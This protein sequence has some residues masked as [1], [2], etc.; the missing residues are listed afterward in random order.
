MDKPL[1]QSISILFAGTFWLWNGFFIVLFYGFF[2]P[3]WAPQLLAAMA[4]G[5]VAPVYLIPLG[6]LLLTPVVSVAV[7]LIQFGGLPRSLLRWFYGVEAPLMLVATLWLFLL[8][9]LTPGAVWTLGAGAACLGTYGLELVGWRPGRRDR[10]G[11]IAVLATSVLMLGLAIGLGALMTLYAIPI[12]WS[13]LTV[14]AQGLGNYQL[15][16]LAAIRDLFFMAFFALSV[17]LLAGMPVSVAVLYWRSGLRGLERS[18]HRWGQRR[19]FWGAIAVLGFWLVALVGLSWQPQHFAFRTLDR[20]IATDGDRQTLMDQRDRLRR[21]LLNAYLQRQRYLGTTDTSSDLADLYRSVLRVPEETAE[22]LQQ[23]RDRLIFPFLYQGHPRDGQR[24]ARLYAALFDE[25]IERGEQEAVQRAFRASASL[26]GA[27]A[28]SLNANERRVLLERQDLNVI[29]HGDWA[30]VEL[31]EVYRNQT[32]E[33]EEVL[34]SFSL[35]ESAVVTGLWL[36]DTGDLA[37]RFS[38]R[39][40]PRGAAQ[41]VYESQVQR[42]APQDPALLEQV[43]PQQYRLRA[44]PVPARLRSWETDLPERPT[45]MH[46]WLTLEVPRQGDRY[47]LPKLLERRNIYWTSRTERRHGELKT[48]TDPAVE[49]PE[50]DYRADWLKNPWLPT[51]IAAQSPQDQTQDPA[52]DQVKN[53]R[54][55]AIQDYGAIAGYRVT[56]EPLPRD[57]IPLPTA[58]RLAVILDTSYSM[59]RQRPALKRLWQ[60][61]EGQGYLDQRL[62]NGDVDLFLPG[63]ALS[64]R[65]PQWLSAVERFDLDRYGFFG[66]LPPQRALGQY[67]RHRADRAP[68][69]PYD[70]VVFV[71]DRGSYELA[72]D[73]QDAVPFQQPLWLLH[74]G[75]Q[76]SEAYDDATLGSIQASGGG[77]ATDIETLLAQVALRRSLAASGSAQAELPFTW[78][79]GYRWRFTAIAP[80]PS[81]AP[82][83]GDPQRDRLESRDRLAAAPAARQLILALAGRTANP[84]PETLDRIHRIATTFGIVTPYSSAIVLVNDEQRAALDRAEASRDRFNRTVVTGKEDEETNPNTASVPEGSPLYGLPIVLLLLWL[85]RSRSPHRRNPA[86]PRP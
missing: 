23:V 37:K 27:A 17:V 82:L 7:G 54:D 9:D 40:S 49:V 28:G 76:L 13:G 55:Q 74:L 19:A 56:A 12:T 24:A 79:D 18:V 59:A 29:P 61:F 60:W 45:A 81:S 43:G 22:A 5:E 77:V 67:Q 50:R 3:F 2:L 31:H 47:P 34:Y 53:N 69:V 44:F 72:G 58:P 48:L 26:D 8:R 4:A 65:A 30:T 46:L 52:Q 16:F 57:R 25:S 42:V 20:P 38:Y 10:W 39:I 1:R 64:N 83:Q 86:P 84:S 14:L 73:R 78:A 41:R 63:D 36:G 21:G 35:P 11:A 66:T 70:A 62:D 6:L 51:A 85:M 15:S 80:S 33:P 71:T 75:G 32:L 68:A